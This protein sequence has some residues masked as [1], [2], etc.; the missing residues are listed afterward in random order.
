MAQPALDAD[1]KA[2]LAALAK[3]VIAELEAFLREWTE[4]TIERIEYRAR[5]AMQDGALSARPVD[6]QPPA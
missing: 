3:E 4:K 5:K 2:F 6:A 1:A